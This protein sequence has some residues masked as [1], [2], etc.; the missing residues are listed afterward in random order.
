MD[1][2]ESAL[3]RIEKKLKEERFEEIWK[4]KRGKQPL[5]LDPDISLRPKLTHSHGTDVQ[6][7]LGSRPVFRCRESTT[8][9]CKDKVLGRKW[10]LEPEGG[11]EVIPKATRDSKKKCT[12]VC[13][14]TRWA[15][16]E[17]VL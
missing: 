13:A 1:E 5:V 8:R 2:V 15:H 12:I 3:K 16:Q 9:H 11:S 10:A 6:I 14:V 4:R 7:S 17:Q